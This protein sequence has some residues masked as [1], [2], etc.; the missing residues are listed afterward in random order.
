MNTH[1]S[2]THPRFQKALLTKYGTN[3]IHQ[4]NPYIIAWWSAALPG[5]GHIL[6]GKHLRGIILFMWEILVNTQSNINIA[7]VHSFTGD[8][9]KAGQILDKQWML[10]YIPV[11]LFSIWDSYRSAISLNKIAV[12][13]NL[14]S[15]GFTISGMAINYYNKN[16][17]LNAVLWSML[18][19]GLGQLYNFQI[20]NSFFLL[21]WTLIIFYFSNFLESI[22]YLFI[23]NPLQ[24][25]QVINKE[26]FMFIPSVYGFA[27]YDAYINTVEQNKLYILDQKQWL[28]KTYQKHLIGITQQK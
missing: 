3:I 9:S 20:I 5:F 1:H 12:L 26:W 16:I 15:S 25:I 10:L 11:Y 13:S 27:I 7:I 23:G 17:P 24:M 14:S 2:Q 6:L 22:Y 21:L 18:L 8:W 19:P 4:R 28:R